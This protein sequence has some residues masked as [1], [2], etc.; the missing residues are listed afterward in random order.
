MKN[1]Q[2]FVNE[3]IK[4]GKKKKQVKRTYTPIIL[5]KPTI[6]YVPEEDELDQIDP[7]IPIPRVRVH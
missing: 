4:A 1:F 3:S 5:P 6:P 2:Q 7:S